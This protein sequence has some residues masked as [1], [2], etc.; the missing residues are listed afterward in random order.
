MSDMSGLAL[1]DLVYCTRPW[2]L[3]VYILQ[4]TYFF[5]IT[6]YHIYVFSVQ[7]HVSN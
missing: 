5:I 6:V 7:G 4:F 3:L 1:H 2:I